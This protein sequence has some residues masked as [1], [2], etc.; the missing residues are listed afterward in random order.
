MSR[1]S[2]VFKLVFHFS[3]SQPTRVNGIQ[4]ASLVV[5]L[6]SDDLRWLESKFNGVVSK[7]R[8]QHE[9]CILWTI[10]NR[11]HTIVC[12]EGIN[13]YRPFTNYTPTTQYLR[14]SIA[15]CIF[16]FKSVS[17]PQ[18]YVRW[19]QLLIC[20]FL[21]IDSYF[22][23]PPNPSTYRMWLWSSFNERYVGSAVDKEV[24]CIVKN[25]SSS[26]IDFPSLCT[27]CRILIILKWRRKQSIW[28][29][30]R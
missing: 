6:G 26:R 3:R 25:N 18:T 30:K 20:S 4:I 5:A 15:T 16:L 2:R 7:L 17:N 29:A 23:I 12:F 21:F 13:C 27:I 9:T 22:L 10:F 24:T 28:L 1:W 11:K 19:Y 8:F 14:I